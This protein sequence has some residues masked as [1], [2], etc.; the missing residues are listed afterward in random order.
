MF[1]DWGKLVLRLAIGGLLLLHGIAKLKNGI[2]W[3]SGPLGAFG[4]PMFVGYG[5]YVGEIIAP[6]LAILG[7]W[8]RLAGLVMAF[9]LLMAVVLVR[10]G[11]VLK[12]NQG[13]GWAIEVEML[14]LIGGVAIFLLGSGRYSLS[15]GQGRWD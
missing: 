15:K 3:M 11:D 10:R 4:L 9:N 8:A 2:G 7:K 14:F 1:Q 12:L 6:V 5:V 13:G